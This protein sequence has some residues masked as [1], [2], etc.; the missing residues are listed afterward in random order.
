MADN[1]EFDGQKY[2]Q[3]SRHQQAW[4]DGLISVMDLTG[5]EDVLDLGCGDGTLTA[6]IAALVPDGSVLG[7]DASAGMLSSAK[8]LGREN[9]AFRQLDINALD[10]DSEFDIIFSNAALHW[11]ADHEALLKNVYRALRPGGRIYWNFAAAS[12]SPTTVRTIQETMAEP[13]FAPFFAE[14]T[15]PWWMPAGDEYRSLLASTAFREAHAEEQHADRYFSDADEM[16]RWLDQPCLV[17]FL[18]A[19]P[20]DR[21]EPFR[22]AVIRKMVER[23]RQPDGTHLEKF[24]RLRVSAEK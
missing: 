19:L 13:E 1:F 3:A 9:L 21:K 10:F 23:T 15:W 18:A 16:I 2:R 7:V 20:E 11:V 17:P 5:S 6:K 24:T 12:S 22:S 4:G 8:E 14:F